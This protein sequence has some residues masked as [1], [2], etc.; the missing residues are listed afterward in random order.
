MAMLA[1]AVR[2]F[3]NGAAVGGLSDAPRGVDRVGAPY[4]CP[5]YLPGK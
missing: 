4:K 5:A 3:G 2:A 1:G